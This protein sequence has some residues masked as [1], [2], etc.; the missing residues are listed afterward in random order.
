MI[1]LSNKV[2]GVEITYIYALSGDIVLRA[3]GQRYVLEVDYYI[4]KEWQDPK[5]IKNMIMNKLK[6]E[7]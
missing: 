4:N 3:E 5:Y 2:N 6:E 7:N 1:I